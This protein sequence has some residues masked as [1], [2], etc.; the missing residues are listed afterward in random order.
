M[1][2]TR[3]VKF[4]TNSQ[5]GYVYLISAVG[6]GRFKIGKTQVGVLGR[7]KELQTG[8]PIKLRYVYHAYVDDINRTEKELIAFNL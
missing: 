5:P 1:I 6:T 3:L 7:L 8:S 2:D 4:K